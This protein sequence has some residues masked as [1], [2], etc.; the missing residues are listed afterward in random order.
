MSILEVNNVSIRYMTGDFKDIGLKEYLL[1][2]IKKSYHV[3]EFWA[4]KNISFSLEQGEM[5]GIIGTNGAGKSTLLKV[6]SGIMEPTK[7]TVRCGGTIAALLELGSGFDG[8]LTV[9]ENTYLRG[10]M[11]GYSR[12]FMDRM[13]AQIIEFAELSD[14]QER[15]FKQLSSGMKSRLAFSIA[16]LVQPDILILDEVL[17]VGDGA[18]REK[19]GAR[20][21]SL[22]ANG[23]TGILVSHSVSQIRE[24]CG[25]VLWLEGGEQ[26]AFGDAQ[27]ICDVYEDFLATPKKSR[28][29]PQNNQEAERISKD[30]RLFRRLYQ[31]EVESGSAV[32]DQ[33]GEAEQRWMK[34]IRSWSQEKREKMYQKYQIDAE[35]PSRN[36][37]P[38]AHGGS[39]APVETPACDML[40]P[41][42]KRV[43]Q[44]AAAKIC[45]AVLVFLL[46]F[47]LC[48]YLNTSELRAWQKQIIAVQDL[49]AEQPLA[50]VSAYHDIQAT[51]PK[52][53]RFEQPWNGY[54]YWLSFSPYPYADDS[55]ENPHIL[56]S[57]DLKLWEEPNGFHNPLDDT[58]EN[59]EHDVVYNS[60]PELF[61][62]GDTDELECW[63]RFVDDS[64]GKTVI[65][66]RRRSKDGVSWTEK[67]AMLTSDRAKHDYLS[68]AIIYENGV[69]KMWSIGSGYRIQYIESSDGHSWSDIQFI[70][71]DY[72]LDTI[73]N[74]HISVIHTAKGYEMVLSA[75][76]DALPASVYKRGVM[77]LYYT[78]SKDNV[79]YKEA[80]ILLTPSQF[81]KAWDGTGLYRSALMRDA[82]DRCYLFY[83]G[84]ASDETRGVGLVELTGKLS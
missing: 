15:P 6:I 55:K 70:S 36:G 56:V 20:M 66:Y 34:E 1:R 69:Y 30:F 27:R 7:G 12:E 65:L 43:S 25:K 51:H 83:S 45:A 81:D 77:N 61:Y 64:N 57:N 80:K 49:N 47:P 14:F 48:N 60:D 13:Y 19:S 8:D 82:D 11:L 18:F 76:D 22:L 75:F 46:F 54:R 73:K 72:P 9:R 33:T 44:K 40:L 79:Q 38:P 39:F 31:E 63:W 5:L 84:I 58:P 59:F 4:D 53:V 24:L 35:N 67:E 78:W 29:T 21:K 62:N 16:C 74:W 26:I 3:Q 42:K 10:A 2:R 37:Q 41:K 32:E 28:R 23:V 71:L 68:P 52:A 17:S 50:L